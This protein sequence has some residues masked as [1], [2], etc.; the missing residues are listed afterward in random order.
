[1]WSKEGVDGIPPLALVVAVLLYL[2]LLV[3]EF[4]G[5]GVWALLLL[6]PEAILRL[7]VWR[8]RP[9]VE[10]TALGLVSAPDVP[11]RSQF[12]QL[13]ESVDEGRHVLQH[14]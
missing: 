11:I 7:E 10:V 14:I 9:R 12:R 5:F 1:M 13:S 4:G 2:E 3:V 8:C 6:G